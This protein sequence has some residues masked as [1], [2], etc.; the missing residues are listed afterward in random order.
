M[1]TLLSRSALLSA[2]LP[3]RDVPVPEMGPGAVVRVQQMSVNA[4]AEYYERIRQ[5]RQA[6]F[7]YDDDQLLPEEQRKGVTKP[8]DLDYALLV[9]VH[10]I[11]DAD[12]KLMFT[13]QDI[14]LFST[15]SNVIVTHIYNACEDLNDFTKS[16]KD[17]VEAEKKG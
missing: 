1:V 16:M 17:D 4:R 6:V 8:V 9:L 13:E 5:H 3:T 2:K 12:G 11:L 10:S 15:W 7:A 14:P